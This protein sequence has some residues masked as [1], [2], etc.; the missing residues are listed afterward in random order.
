MNLASGIYRAGFRAGLAPDPELTVSAWA[1]AHRVLPQQASAEPGAW[2]TDRTPYLREIMDSLSA[3]DAV[4]TVVFMKGAQLGGTEAGNNWLGYIIHHAPGPALFVQPTVEMAK[5]TSKQRI[6][7]MIEACPALAE[8]VNPARSRDAGNTL[9]AKEFPGGILVM[10][11]ANSAVGLRSMPAR[12]LFL[13]EVDGYEADVDG[14][15]DPVEL[16]VKR[17][18]TYARNR[19]VFIVSTPTIRGVS[20]IEAAWERSDQRYY[21]VPCPHCDAMAPILWRNLRWDEGRPETACL[22]CE[23]CGGEIAERHKEAMLA[24]GAWV[25]TQESEVRGYHLS[26][27]YSPLGWYSWAQAAADFLEAKRI[28]PEGLKTWTNTVLGETWEEQGDAVEDDLL[29]ARREQYP[30]EVPAAALVLTA[31]IDVQDDRLEMEVVGWGKGEESW[32]IE[33]RTLWG[34]PGRGLVWQELDQALARIYRHESGHQLRVVAACIDSG[35]ATQQ[36]Y[37]HVLR[38]RAGG[39]HAVKG[40]AGSGRPIV[41]APSKHKTGNLKR[42]VPVF[43]VGVDEAKGLVYSRLRLREPGPGYCHFPIGEGYDVEYFAQLTAEKCV[44]RYTR[45]FPRREWVKVRARNEALD[46]RVYALSAVYILRP[47]WD[48][49]DLRLRVTVAG[50]GGAAS[51][52]CIPRPARR[53]PYAT[54]WR[55]SW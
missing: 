54:R 55:N 40:V 4:E 52:K 14:E 1:D 49:L 8:R 23:E 10:T 42:P 26:S 11:G 44:T 34:D 29:I 25:P 48:L 24:A 33:Y 27:L 47:A 6:G 39:L 17:T 22:Y 16:A 53:G 12:Y 37:E 38:R 28:G 50:A 43:L 35:H 15:G 41:S 51:P 20:R 3:S 46:C 36:V 19:K 21:Q 18:A 7:P 31:G 13:D 2:R 5:R 9:L 30:A 45:G 32:G